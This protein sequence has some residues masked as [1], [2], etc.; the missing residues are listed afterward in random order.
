MSTTDDPRMSA[1][2]GRRQGRAC[3]QGRAYKRALYSRRRGCSR[4]NAPHA[5]HK[6]PTTSAVIFEGIFKSSG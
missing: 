4:N 2:V 5:P 1:W 6:H 3:K